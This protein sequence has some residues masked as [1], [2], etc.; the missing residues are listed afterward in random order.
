MIAKNSPRWG[1]ALGK[2]LAANGYDED[3]AL[4]LMG[5]LMQGQLQQA[6]QEL[7]KLT[8]ELNV[9]QLKVHDHTSSSTVKAYQAITERMRVISESDASENEK[10][11]QMHQL[12]LESAK[13]SHEMDQDEREGKNAE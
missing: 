5:Q 8:Q 13:V 1:E 9:S 7:N 10:M 2:I 3:N 11:I 12:I 6:M 4:G